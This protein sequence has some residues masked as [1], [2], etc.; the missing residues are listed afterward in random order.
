MVKLQKKNILFALQE[1]EGIG[2]LMG[3]DMVDAF[4]QNE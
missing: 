4:N 1:L 2:I 3:N